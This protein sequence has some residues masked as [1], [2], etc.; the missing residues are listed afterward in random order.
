[1]SRSETAILKEFVS[2]E[3]GRQ[4]IV[5]SVVRMF[6]LVRNMLLAKVMDMDSY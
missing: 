3:A 5:V 2:S 1:M 6:P 4:G